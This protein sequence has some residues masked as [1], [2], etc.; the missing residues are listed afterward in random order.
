MDTLAKSM[1]SL[2]KEQEH[3]SVHQR[4]IA[5]ILEERWKE[6]GDDGYDFS[7]TELP[8]ASVSSMVTR[9]PE[10]FFKAKRGFVSLCERR[11]EVEEKYGNRSE[12]E[13]QD[14]E[15]DSEILTP[16]GILWERSL[17]DNSLPRLLGVQM[18]GSKP[19][20]FAK[21]TGIYILYDHRDII[22]IGQSKGKLG[23]RIK[24]H[25]KTKDGLKHRWN[26][27]SWFGILPVTQD[28]K[29]GTT[30]NGLIQTMPDF[31]ESFAIKLTNPP[32]NRTQGNGLTDSE[33]FP[34]RVGI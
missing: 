15:Y 16:F 9:N 18:E 4:E 20:D 7:G 34:I 8:F 17:I 23:Q 10:V 11:K 31:L 24:Q 1:Q 14:S 5:Q 21:Q 33:F 12:V 6:G 26:R 30:G 27:F 29:L 25:T 2:L 28:G 22:Y 32:E 3:L 13:D 19:V